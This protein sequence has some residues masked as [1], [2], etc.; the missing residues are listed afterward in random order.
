MTALLEPIAETTPIKAEE[1]L[2][3]PSTNSINL[4]KVSLVKTILSLL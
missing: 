1:A 2:P 4:L 3:M